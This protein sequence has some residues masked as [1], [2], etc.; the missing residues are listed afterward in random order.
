MSE[1]I[2]YGN[3][4]NSIFQLIG[5][6]EDDITKSIA[7]AFCNCP[8]FLKNILQNLLN[9]NV[10]PDKV[11]I[12]F[13]VDEK[14]KGR[15]DLELTDNELFHIIIE[16]KRGW[17]LPQSAQLT[18]YS[19]RISFVS[20][21]AKNKAIVSMSDCSDVYAN[22]YLPF[23]QINGVPVKHLS[24]RQIYNT[25]QN[26]ISF[27]NNEQKHLLNEL[28]TYLEGLMTMQK[29]NSNWVYVVSLSYKK[30]T[31]CNISWIDIVRNYKKYFHPLGMN[32]WPKE[33]P[34]YI[35][36]RYNGCLQSIHHIENYTVTKNLHNEIPAMPNHIEDDSYFVYTLGTP[37]IPNKVVKTGNIYASGRKWAMLDTLLTAD[38]IAEASEISYERMK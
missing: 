21:T 38:T 3:R 25:A 8:I 2:A 15:T 33:P 30:P 32:G 13:Q 18:M 14:E 19:K 17:I 10:S 16:A 11:I 20:S 4:V 31:D 23:H 12:S 9:I 29:Q 7:W 6:S 37:I 36:F 24:W 34:N 27:S 26:S 5:K 28:M 22:T 1:L 35:A